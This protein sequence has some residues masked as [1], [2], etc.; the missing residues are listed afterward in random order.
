MPLVAAQSVNELQGARAGILSATATFPYTGSQSEALFAIVARARY[1]ATAGLW[2]FSFGPDV[3]V[4]LPPAVVEMN[5]STAWEISTLSA[6]F[7]IDVATPLA[8]SW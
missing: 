6:G 7:C 2:R 8:G 4:N 1:L 3:A 5:G